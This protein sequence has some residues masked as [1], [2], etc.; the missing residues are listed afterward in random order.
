MDDAVHWPTVSLPPS[1]T[2]PKGYGARHEATLAQYEEREQERLEELAQFEELVT[3]LVS[4]TQQALTRFVQHLDLLPLLC[5]CLH[6]RTTPR[7]PRHVEAVDVSRS[8]R[9]SRSS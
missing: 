4:G 9:S 6:R 3:V 2:C 5:A 7:N 8:S 1:T